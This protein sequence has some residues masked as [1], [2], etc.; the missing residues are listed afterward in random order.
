MRREAPREK[1]N[2]WLQEL[3]VSFP[4]NFKIIY[5]IKPVWSWCACLFSLTLTVEIQSYVTLRLWCMK[6]VLCES[7]LRK[8]SAIK[9]RHKFFSKK[10]HFKFQTNA[11]PPKACNCH[12][13]AHCPLDSNCLKSAVIYMYQATVATQD[14]RPAETYVGLT[15]NSFKTRYLNH[16]SSF[17]DPNKYRTQYAQCCT[18]KML[19]LDLA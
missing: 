5:L 11:K 1:N 9:K 3:R 8:E 18:W 10:I 17:R 16:K 4:F 6:K 13:P 19:R 2:L 15:E 7:L 12:Q 14:N